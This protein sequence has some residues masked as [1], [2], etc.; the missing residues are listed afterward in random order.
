MFA[1]QDLSEAAAAGDCSTARESLMD[2]DSLIHQPTAR[3]NCSVDGPTHFLRHGRIYSGHP[4]LLRIQ[5]VDGRDRP[6]HDEL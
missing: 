3:T 1:T 6:G 4:R 5:D 2:H